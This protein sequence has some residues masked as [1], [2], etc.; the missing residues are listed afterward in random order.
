M[1]RQETTNQILGL[2]AR[3]NTALVDTVA[4]GII[5]CSIAPVP[6]VSL[7]AG[8]TQGDCSALLLL[9]VYEHAVCS[10]Q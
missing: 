7:A 8:N 10:L 1:G 3:P 2:T 5:Y 9:G 4:V 6:L